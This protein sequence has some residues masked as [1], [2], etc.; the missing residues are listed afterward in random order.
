MRP[1]Q[2][3][4]ARFWAKVE[5]P[6]AAGHQRWLGAHSEKRGYPARP[7]FW[8]A[9]LPAGG[10]VIVP[11]FRLALSLTDGVPLYDREG[12]FACHRPSCAHPWCVNPAHG[13][14]GTREENHRDRYGASTAP[15]YRFD[16]GIEWGLDQ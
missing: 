2:D 11:A 4:A 13:Y 14:W 8:I 15:Q 1:R 10:H 6:D 7:I 16:P 3:L 9:Q 12:W 5:A